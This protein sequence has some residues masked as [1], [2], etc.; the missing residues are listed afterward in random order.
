MNTI[1][2]DSTRYA[3][4]ERRTH[5]VNKDRPKINIDTDVSQCYNNIV[6]AVTSLDRHHSVS[7]T[8]RLRTSKVA[9]N[10]AN[11]DYSV[12]LLATA[13]CKIY[14]CSGLVIVMRRMLSRQG[15]LLAG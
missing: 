7:N 5:T 14:T 3:T 10:I 6:G 15:E 8:A 11:N 13:A 12:A 1:Q 9:G 2:F 4:I